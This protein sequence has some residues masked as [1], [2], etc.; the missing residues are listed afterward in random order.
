MALKNRMVGR[1]DG[2]TNFAA[3]DFIV[4]S[5][6]TVNEGDFVYFA[7][8]VVTNA[9]VAG[10]RLLGMAMGTA[11]GNAGGTVKVTVCV[12]PNMVY[13]IDND[14]IGTTFAS[15]HV[16]TS[17]DLIGATGAQL[18]DTS[19]TGTTGSVTCVEYNPKIDPVATDTSWGL[20]VITE[21]AL[22]TGTG[23]Q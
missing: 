1:I 21:N 6:V 12:D 22:F 16:G 13:L 10:A 7:S 2:E 11:T 17:F 20:Y 14:N 5:G 15:T 8:G 3:R 19:T 18:V 9:T 23:A 4:G